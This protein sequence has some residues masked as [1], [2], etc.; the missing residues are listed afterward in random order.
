MD[1]NVNE[2]KAVKGGNEKKTIDEKIA[3]KELEGKLE[4]MKA[5]RETKC[6]AAKEQ[7]VEQLKVTVDKYRTATGTAEALRT[8]RFVVGADDVHL[9]CAN[10]LAWDMASVVDMMRKKAEGLDYGMM[11]DLCDEFYEKEFKLEYDSEKLDEAYYK[12][13]FELMRIDLCRNVGEAAED[14]V[15]FV[16]RV[17]EEIDSTQAELDKLLEIKADKDKWGI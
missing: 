9:T 6:K 4:S 8:L 13:A 3:I 12:L 15:S 7:L 17:Q 14:M 2:I 1:K 11:D 16:N 5:D 10:R